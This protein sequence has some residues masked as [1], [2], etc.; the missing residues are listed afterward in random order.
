MDFVTRHTISQQSKK[1]QL[2][3]AEYL[4]VVTS[5]GHVTLGQIQPSSGL[6]LAS[7]G[8]LVLLKLLPPGMLPGGCLG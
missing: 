3:K 7:P 4:C 8:F 5:G 1:P 6:L 2:P